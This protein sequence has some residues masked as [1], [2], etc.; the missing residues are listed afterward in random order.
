MALDLTHWGYSFLLHTCNL[1]SQTRTSTNPFTGETVESTMDAGLTDDEINALQ[2]VFDENGID[3]PEPEGE[4]YAAYRA[5][6]ESL[7][8]RCNDLDEGEPIDGIAA[9]VVVKQLSDEL[10]TI[11]LDVARA[12]NL[13]LTSSVGDC[14]RVPIRD[15]DHK[16]LQRWPDAVAV[17]SIAELRQWLQESIGGRKLHVSS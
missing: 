15:P 3:G 13:V 16:L 17:S 4:G 5:E 12:G 7:R 14:V 8:F 9:E 10:L 6:G 11:I 1:G 2:D